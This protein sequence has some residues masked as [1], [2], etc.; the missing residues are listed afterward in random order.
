MIDQPTALQTFASLL[1]ENPR[2]AIDTESNSLHAYRERVCL[3]QISLPHADYLIDPLALTDLATLAP[4]F[5]NPQK[6]KVFHASEYDLLCLRRTFGFRVRGVFDTYAAVR[7]L[8]IKECGLGNVLEQEMGVHLDKHFQRANWSKRPLT[9][10]QMEY[11]RLDTHYL[12]ALRD[13]LADRVQA[14]GLQ[15]ELEEEFLRLESLPDA[16][17]ETK[18]FP[19]FWR[20]RGVFDL[21]PH[22]RAALHALY[23]WREQEAERIDRPPFY[24]LAEEGMVRIAQQLPANDSDLSACGLPAS[25]LMRHGD[26][27]LRLVARAR[28]EPAPIPP[29]VHRLDDATAERLKSLQQWRKKKAAARG[30]ESDVILSKDVLL[31]IA[32]TAPRSQ[33]ALASLEGFGPWKQARYGT[34]ILDLL[35]QEPA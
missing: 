6:E 27:L 12:L 1:E 19:G 9:E 18:R 13:L 30:V 25:I 23:L 35:K 2:A 26:T 10:A 14:A 20:I 34:E 8:G 24:V 21:P 28:H 22:K 33:E 17:L 16:E 32:Q 11:A 4:F 3:I 29:P 7:A 15:M 31:L 5:E